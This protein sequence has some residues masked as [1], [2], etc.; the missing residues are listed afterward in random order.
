[1]NVK[2]ERLSIGA[3]ILESMQENDDLPLPN[4]HRVVKTMMEYY[5]QDGYADDLK[6]MGSCWKPTEDYWRRNINNVAS[7]LAE[8]SEPFS[9]YR[10]YGDF[11]GMWKFCNKKEYETIIRRDHADIATRTDNHNQ[12]LDESKW[13][14]QLPHLAEVPL[15]N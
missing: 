10:E 7:L 13:D 11:K 4:I 2:E 3:D 1:V 12:K 6:E 5:K 8:R 15:L 9:F 14:L